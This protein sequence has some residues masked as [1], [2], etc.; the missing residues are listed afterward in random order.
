MT[1][2]TA[3]VSVRFL[4]GLGMGLSRFDALNDV[5]VPIAPLS[6]LIYHWRKN[7]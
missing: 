6:I 3:V 5:F 1:C 4:V 2:R 7:S